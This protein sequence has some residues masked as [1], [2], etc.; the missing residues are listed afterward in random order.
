MGRRSE[1]FPATIRNAFDAI[2]W[3]DHGW[4]WPVRHSLGGIEFGRRLS[5]RFALG[6]PTFGSDI[7]RTKLKNGRQFMNA[8]SGTIL[9]QT[10]T[11]SVKESECQFAAG[12]SSTTSRFRTA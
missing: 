5:L 12:R 2:G 7:K 3:L 1:P 11:L 10:P 6:R 8:W 9:W 4:Y